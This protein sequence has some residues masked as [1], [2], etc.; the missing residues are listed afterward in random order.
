MFLRVRDGISFHAV[1]ADAT[2]NEMLL[3]QMIKRYCDINKVC[4]RLQL[5]AT[6]HLWYLGL[7]PLSLFSVKVSIE[8]KS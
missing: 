5:K 8:D 1:G 2:F 6:N 7:V 4:H 3:F